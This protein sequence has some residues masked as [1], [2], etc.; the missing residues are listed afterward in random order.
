MSSQV[1]LGRCMVIDN[2]ELDLKERNRK[3]DV[4][5]MVVNMNGPRPSPVSFFDM[6]P[7]LSNYGIYIMI[8]MEDGS[9][10]G[11]GSR[12]KNKPRFALDRDYK[13]I[14]FKLDNY[15]DGISLV[16]KERESFRKAIL[17]FRII[18]MLCE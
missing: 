12:I 11:L 16:C 8:K 1:F 2:D 5:L 17:F 18:S 10:I 13:S 9:S 3:G 15:S 14:T 4:T 6:V 7:P